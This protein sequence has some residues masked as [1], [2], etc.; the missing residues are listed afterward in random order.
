MNKTVCVTVA[1]SHP[2]GGR[3]PGPLPTPWGGRSLPRRLAAG[4][5]VL[6]VGSG[7]GCCSPALTVSSRQ[8]DST[9]ARVTLSCTVRPP[10]DVSPQPLPGTVQTD[11]AGSPRPFSAGIVAARTVGGRCWRVPFP[12]RGRP[13]P[14]LLRS[15]V[16]SARGSRHAGL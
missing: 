16:L 8:G 10:A 9:P 5:S 3:L 15:S 6:R 7:H 4:R 2:Q 12:G 14:F 11:S 1:A 13:T